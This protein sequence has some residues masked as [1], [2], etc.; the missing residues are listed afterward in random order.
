MCGMQPSYGRGLGRVGFRWSAMEGI[1]RAA[2]PVSAWHD[3]ARYFPID[4]PWM[5]FLFLSNM[6]K[7]DPL[8]QTLFDA[9][10]FLRVK[11]ECEPALVKAIVVI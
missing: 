10:P 4:R 5:V 3:I 7:R 11:F 1:L 6:P 2:C 8:I 9:E